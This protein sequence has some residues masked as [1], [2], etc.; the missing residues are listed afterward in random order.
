MKRV[1]ICQSMKSF[2]ASLIDR[3]DFA[4][5][6]KYFESHQ[7]E[8]ESIGGSQ[9]GEVIHLASK[10]YASAAHLPVALKVAR[11]AQHMIV[12][13]GDCLLL[14]EIFLTIGV[15][16]RDMSEFKEAEKAFRDAE[17]IFR[18]NDSLQGQGKALNELAG[19]FFRQTDYG[20]SLDA[21]MDAIEIARKLGDTK[22]LAY[23]TGNIGRIQTFTGDFEEAVKNLRINIELSER[24][25]EKYEVL[26]AYL[27]LGYV[28]M[29]K[30]DYEEAEK[31]LND[32]Y[33]RIVLTS[34]TRHEVIYLTYL[35]ELR[36]RVGNLE[37]SGEILR[38]A[39]AL[40]HEISP[41]STLE[42]RVLRH[43][44]ELSL[45][46]NELRNAERYCASSW[47]MM[48]R[49]KNKVELGALCKIRA[50]IAEAR[51]RGR[52]GRELYVRAINLLSD[53]KVR[54]EKADALAAAGK[55]ELFSLRQRLTY[56]FRAEEIYAHYRL[57]RKQR[58]IE[59]V[60]DELDCQRL[61]QSD[62][63]VP[64]SCSSDDDFDYHTTCPEIIQFKNQLPLISRSDLPILLMGETGVG[65]DHLARYYQKMVRPNGPFV[66]INCA[67]LPETLLESE[68]FGYQK[69]AFTGAD[70][71]KQGLLVAANGG[72]LFLDEIG[73]MPLDLQ[74]KLLGVLESRRL[75][76]LGSTTS[77]EL[78]IKIVAATNRK[79]ED[80]VESGGFRRDLY[81]RLSGVSFEIPPLRERKE[82]I[83]VLLN[84]FMKRCG[85]LE[86][87][88]SL[89]AELVRQFIEH[90]WPG[91]VREL[92]NKVKRLEVMALMVA[93]GDLVELARSVFGG[94]MPDSNDSLFDR[95][96][97]FEKKIIL[98]AL[99][100]A[101]GNK[102]EAARMLGVHEA[103]VRTKL[104]RYGLSSG[105]Y[106]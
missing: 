11:T 48:E 97:E 73:D 59:R 23:M 80:M 39:Q 86:E 60:I 103:T 83:P 36:Y 1:E 35:G 18:R 91:N 68:L 14:A 53:S 13:E 94:E 67:S 40:A 3:K 92:C 22:K 15:I 38:K 62:N 47:V 105:R 87:D 96:E 10:A 45:S 55:S 31:A 41:G 74:T 61:R 98:E 9:A 52:E 49:G 56:L 84:L 12:E 57:F 7:K 16:L 90:D 75:I 28:L 106:N 85:L 99:L 44:A 21:L 6:I 81:Y 20:N 4:G 65:K 19:L 51:K 64:E 66:A 8:L 50:M 46:L 24:S 27:S 2:M 29:L 33:T 71:N 88:E 17:S 37:E 89:P 54:F 42:G 72:V 104:K 69:G 79:L 25:G 30:A 101:Q 93:E 70:K 5:A 95:V 82:D 76:P 43:L 32:A 34:D 58:E 100:A 102:S 63:T 77:V 26:K 78:D